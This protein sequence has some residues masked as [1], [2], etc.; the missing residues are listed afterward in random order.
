MW[1]QIAHN[2]IEWD[3][4]ENME[5]QEYQ[6]A[7]KQNQTLGFLIL[8][9]KLRFELVQYISFLCVGRFC[10]ISHILPRLEF[11]QPN[12]F[13]LVFVWAFHFIKTWDSINNFSLVH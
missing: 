7:R 10:V 6:K 3:K 8:Q 2:S 13:W 1:L 9:L 12:E 5:W 4:Q 11:L